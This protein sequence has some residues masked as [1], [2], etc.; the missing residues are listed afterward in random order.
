MTPV[1]VLLS[2]LSS[3]STLFDVAKSES[4]PAEGASSTATTVIRFD[5]AVERPSELPPYGEL[6]IR[7]AG[8]S[9]TEAHTVRCPRDGRKLRCELPSG[10]LDLKLRVGAF[11]PSFFWGVRVEKAQE[12]TLGPVSLLAGSTVSGQLELGGSRGGPESLDRAV[13]TAQ[14]VFHGP[15]ARPADLSRASLRQLRTHPDRRGFFAIAGLAAGEYVLHAECEQWRSTAARVVVGTGEA[16]VAAPA[17]V[18][19]PPLTLAVTV[20]PPFMPSGQPW[21]IE[22]SR[23]DDLSEFFATVGEGLTN[24]EGGWRMSGLRPGAVEVGVSDEQGSTWVQESV[25]LE[26][27]DLDLVLAVPLVEIV[28]SLSLGGEPIAGVL[29]FGGERRRPRIRMEADEKGRFHGY[30]PRPGEWALDLQM[31]RGVQGHPPIDIVPKEGRARVDID[32]P[33]TLVEGR[34]VD[35]QGKPVGGAEV[36]AVTVGAGIRRRELQATAKNDGTFSFWGIAPGELHV[37]ARSADRASE[38]ARL[39][40][41]EDLEPPPLTLVLAAVTKLE[42]VVTA[43]GGPRAGVRVLAISQG[44]PAGLSVARETVTRSDGRFDVEIPARRASVVLIGNGLP[45]Q[46]FS[47]SPG[48]NV[49]IVYEMEGPAGQLALDLTNVASGSVGIAEAELHQHGASV[50]FFHLL[51]SGAVAIHDHEAVIPLASAG[52]VAFCAAGAC[53]SGRLEPSATLRLSPPGRR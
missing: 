52:D 49:P 10:E 25:V 15:V 9:A 6:E 14:P 3:G 11:A 27:G 5:L 42:G 18:L 1:V 51:R 8:K 20:E 12:R 2:L 41:R 13:I 28:G 17:L 40:V 4:R 32:L 26:D 48:G 21:R 22:V 36:I 30:L 47:W 45:L 29:W 33:R 19:Q 53:A 38:L 43:G 44:G 31:A 35:E 37:H 24:R 23:Q 34:A 39:D 46:L 50:S 7:P 16:H